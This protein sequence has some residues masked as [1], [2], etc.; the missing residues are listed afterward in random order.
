MSIFPSYFLKVIFYVTT[1]KVGEIVIEKWS[2]RW[3]DLLA[4]ML[5]PGPDLNC[6]EPLVFWGF[7]QHLPAKCR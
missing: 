3:L 6:L 1:S 4:S 7:S 5:L 2:N